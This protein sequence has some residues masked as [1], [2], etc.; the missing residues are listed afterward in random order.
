MKILAVGLNYRTHT[1]ELPPLIGGVELSRQEHRPIIF[2]K[3]DS[4]LRPQMPFF[5]PEWSSQIDYEAE[6]VVQI[7][8]VG[9]CIAERFAHRYYSKLSIGIDFTARDLQRDAIAS[10]L[11]W[12][13]SKAFDNAAAIGQWVDKAE[14]GYPASPIELR[15]DV[16]GET[17]Q[18]AL[19]SEMIHSIDRL[20]AYVSQQHTLKMGDILF[21]GT[22]AGVGPCRIGQSLDGYLAGRHL[23]HV[24]IK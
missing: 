9:K 12:T 24:E 1:E 19:S 17:R 21:T 10:G 3:G 18:R 11:P 8:R 16:D 15:L 23:L 20:I 2:H 5:L 6:I 13:E 7:D 22:P 14:L 4:V